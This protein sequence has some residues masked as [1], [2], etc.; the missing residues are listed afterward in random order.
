MKLFVR[1]TPPDAPAAYTVLP[2]GSLGS[3]AMDDTRPAVVFTSLASIWPAGPTGV[4][5]SL[6]ISWEPSTRAIRNEAVV[7]SATSSPRPEL[8]T[9]LSRNS[10][11]VRT[12]P[13]EVPRFLMTSFQVPWE[14]W[15]M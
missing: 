3:T 14:A 12:C 2:D 13:V 6:A 1:H 5:L 11:N 9:G 8:M 10:L 15:L 7:R 4:Q